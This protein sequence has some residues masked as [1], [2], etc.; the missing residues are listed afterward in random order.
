MNERIN[1]IG[2]AQRLKNKGYSN[3]AAATMMGI[4]ESTFRT[5][6]VR[7]DHIIKGEKSNVCPKCGSE[8]ITSFSYG[9]FT[10]KVTSF[11]CGP[12]T[13]RVCQDCDV[14]FEIPPQRKD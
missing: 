12:F 2:Q 10:Q 14:M 3:V 6:L 11:S 9:P 5:L 7:G 13:I 4:S 1:R 8:N